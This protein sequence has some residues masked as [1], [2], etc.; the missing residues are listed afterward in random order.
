M[1]KYLQARLAERSTWVGMGAS[2]TATVVAVAALQLPQVVTI[3]LTVGIAVTG[4]IASLL[5]TGDVPK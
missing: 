4:L 3:G 1:F 5:P 2:L